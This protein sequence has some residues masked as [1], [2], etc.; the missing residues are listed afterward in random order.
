M[1]AFRRS[2]FEAKCS[3]NGEFTTLS[4]CLPSDCGAAPEVTHTSDEK[5]SAVFS[6]S[7]EYACGVGYTLDATPDG[8]SGFELQ[9]FHDGVCSSLFTV[10]PVKCGPPPWR[11][12]STIIQQRRCTTRR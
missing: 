1:S 3:G 10:L 6:E 9:C 8:T 11:N 7:V 12:H 5:K 4:E 2:Q